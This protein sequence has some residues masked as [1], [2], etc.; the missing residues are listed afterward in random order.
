[1]KRVAPREEITVRSPARM[2]MRGA[3]HRRHAH[4][5]GTSTAACGRKMAVPRRLPI[6]TEVAAT[7]RGAHARVWAPGHAKVTLVIDAP[8]REI[9]LGREPGGYHSGFAPGLG[10]GDRYAFRLGDDRALYA[11]P[12]SRYQ[13]DG[14]L[15]PSQ[16]VDPAA[17]AWT[18][19]AWAGIAPDRHVMYE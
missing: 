9:V 4:A 5:S 3:A 11:D 16:V 14:P 19:G 12:A 8:R 2:S 13:P 10:A 18:D 6:G 7:E 15:G 1:M 17:F